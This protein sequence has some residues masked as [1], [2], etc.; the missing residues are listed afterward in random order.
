MS[1]IDVIFELLLNFGIYNMENIEDKNVICFNIPDFDFFENKDQI[2]EKF[3]KYNKEIGLLRIKTL[4]N[5]NN[6]KYVLVPI[7]TNINIAKIN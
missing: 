4:D 5:E 1:N 2:I 7:H 3:K 6:I